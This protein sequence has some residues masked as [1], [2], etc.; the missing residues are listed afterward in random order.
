[1][2]EGQKIWV[3]QAGGREARPGVYVG[4]SEEVF[5]GV[6]RAYVVYPDTGEGEAVELM[7]II[8]RDDDG[9][10]EQA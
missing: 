5:G 6:P 10:S 1:M 3:E 8:P 4:E 2:E 9:G 7:R